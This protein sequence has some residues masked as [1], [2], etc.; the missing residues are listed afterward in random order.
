M[1][2]EKPLNLKRKKTNQL[3]EENGVAP[4]T[5]WRWVKSGILPKP[6]K[7]NGQNYW[8]ADTDPKFDG[9]G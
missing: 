1:T 2:N 4:V 8:P 5:I 3:C 7:I 9:E 6:Q